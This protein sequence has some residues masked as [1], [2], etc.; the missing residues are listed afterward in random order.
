MLVLSS[1]YKGSFISTV[2]VREMFFW[3][4]ISKFAGSIFTDR[5]TTNN[6]RRDL[7]EVKNHLE[8]NINVIFFPE[9]RAFDGSKV[10]D[11]KRPFFTPAF[12]LKKDLIAITINYNSINGEKLKPA[13][14]NLLFWYRQ[15]PLLGHI[16]NQFK[17]QSVEVELFI[18]H[19]KSPSNPID[20]KKTVQHLHSIINSNFRSF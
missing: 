5:R 9:A 15:V 13:D 17:H 7:I 4:L 11:F 2:E 3:G 14:K 6:L 10:L 18:N 8:N 12:D 16:M 1:I 19:L 20:N